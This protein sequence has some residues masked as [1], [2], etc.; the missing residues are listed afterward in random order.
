MHVVSESA[1]ICCSILFLCG[2]KP[3]FDMTVSDS[4][5]VL[6]TNQINVSTVYKG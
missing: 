2:F 5:T 1:Q 4:H 6:V 3:D